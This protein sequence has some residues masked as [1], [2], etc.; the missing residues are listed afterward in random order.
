MERRKGRIRSNENGNIK[1]GKCRGIKGR[2]GRRTM[3]AHC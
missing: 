3:V 1:K 2:R